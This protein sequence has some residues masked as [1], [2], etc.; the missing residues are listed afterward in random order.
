MFYQLFT[1]HITKHNQAFPL[2]YDLLPNKRQTHSLVLL[3]QKVWGLPVCIQMV[4]AELIEVLSLLSHTAH[5]INLMSKSP[6]LQVLHDYTC[7]DPP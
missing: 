5:W 7:I 4:E 3:L 1:M 6:V 2:V